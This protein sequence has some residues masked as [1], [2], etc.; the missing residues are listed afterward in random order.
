M[1]PWRVER[2]DTVVVSFAT[3]LGNHQT[4]TAKI[5]WSQAIE[6]SGRFVAGM[7][8]DEELSLAV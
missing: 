8:F 3:K 2:G 1:L 4:R 6:T 7:S 5:A